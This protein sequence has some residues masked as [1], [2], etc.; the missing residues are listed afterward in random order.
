MKEYV[1]SHKTNKKPGY[2]TKGLTQE[3]QIIAEQSTGQIFF[4]KQDG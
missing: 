1:Q 3:Q 2:H 4:S